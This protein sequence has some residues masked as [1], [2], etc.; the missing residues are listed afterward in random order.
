MEYS[1]SSLHLHLILV[2]PWFVGLIEEFVSSYWVYQNADWV[3]L[4]C[5]IRYPLGFTFYH[6]TLY[7]I[8]TSSADSLWR[9]SPCVFVVSWP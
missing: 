7:Y 2:R 8:F 6:F 5:R 9:C 3:C 1:L 4:W